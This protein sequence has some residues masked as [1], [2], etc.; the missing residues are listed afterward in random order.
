MKIEDVEKLMQDTEEAIQYQN[1]ISEL[2]SG[3]LTLED[4]EGIESELAQIIEKQ[5]SQL[6]SLPKDLKQPNVQVEEP[7]EPE[8]QE[9]QLVA[10]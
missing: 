8:H 9:K 4:E 7:E 10:A 3:A 1:E 5:T 6:P 2:L